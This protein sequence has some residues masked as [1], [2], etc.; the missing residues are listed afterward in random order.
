VKQA[1][2][3]HGLA[4]SIRMSEWKRWRP[5]HGLWLVSSPY[6]ALL[7]GFRPSTTPPPTPPLASTATARLAS[8]GLAVFSRLG[9]SEPGLVFKGSIRRDCFWG[10]RRRVSRRLGGT[11]ISGGPA[12]SAPAP[13]AGCE[14][15]QKTVSN[16]PNPAQEPTSRAGRHGIEGFQQLDQLGHIPF[17]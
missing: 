5:W 6:R 8:R 3:G 13:R 7:H 4:G 17:D 11:P 12:V 10:L 2:L 1:Q 16:P 14:F 15:S 9:A